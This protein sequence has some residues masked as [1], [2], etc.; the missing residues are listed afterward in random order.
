MVFFEFEVVYVG[1]GFELEEV[2][3][4]Y[5][6]GVGDVGVVFGFEDELGVFGGCVVGYFV[7]VVFDENV[8]EFVDSFDM[9]GVMFG[10]DIFNMKVV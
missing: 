4:S 6:D 8:F 1:V 10:F 9:F 2:E 3:V 5:D 7:G